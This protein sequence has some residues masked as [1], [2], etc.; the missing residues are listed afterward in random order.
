[1]SWAWRNAFPPF[2]NLEGSQAAK[3]AFVLL[4]FNMQIEVVTKLALIFTNSSIF[5]TSIEHHEILQ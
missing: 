3:D 1:M 4:I 5:I 2:I